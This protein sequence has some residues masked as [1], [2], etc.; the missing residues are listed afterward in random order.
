[1]NGLTIYLI[2]GKWAKP[3]IIVDGNTLRIILGFVGIGI[4]LCDLE[5]FMS[6]V[7]ETLEKESIKNDVC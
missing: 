2:F 4:M 3:N 5:I 6:E 7:L 1:M